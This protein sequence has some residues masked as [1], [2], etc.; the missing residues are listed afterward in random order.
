MAKEDSVAPETEQAMEESV[1]NV[2]KTGFNI[3][4][5][6]CIK[7]LNEKKVPNNKVDGEDAFLRVEK[8]LFYQTVLNRTLNHRNLNRFGMHL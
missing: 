2:N 5:R 7:M 1:V 8:R 4:S 6:P 3:D